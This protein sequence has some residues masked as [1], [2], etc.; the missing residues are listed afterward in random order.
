M[1]RV[2]LYKADI[3]STEMLSRMQGLLRMMKK[4]LE[5]DESARIEVNCYS[6]LNYS[7]ASGHK[8]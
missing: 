1:K 5:G 6:D 2:R 4:G 7:Q 8:N 3:H